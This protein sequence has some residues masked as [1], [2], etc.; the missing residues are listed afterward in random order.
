MALGNKCPNCGNAT[1][2]QEGPILRCSRG[3]C[4][5]VGW[6]GTPGQPGAGS[7][8]VCKRCGGRYVRVIATMEDG[9]EALYCY[10]CSANFLKVS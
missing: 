6:I 9:V 2:H 5:A 10:S 7:G 3:D 1:W 4:G 8:R